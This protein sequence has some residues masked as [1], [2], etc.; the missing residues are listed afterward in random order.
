MELFFFR[1]HRQHP[2][3]APLHTEGET[4]RA[5]GEKASETAN[6]VTHLYKSYTKKESEGPERGDTSQ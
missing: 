2:T 4:H 1:E 5:C 6:N 3:Q